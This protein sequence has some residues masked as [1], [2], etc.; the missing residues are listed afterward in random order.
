MK[1][2]LWWQ[3]R[4]QQFC[5]ASWFSGNLV[6]RRCNTTFPHFRVAFTKLSKEALEGLPH[7]PYKKSAYFRSWPAGWF[8]NTRKTS[9]TCSKTFSK[10]L[11][12]EA[13]PIPL[14]GSSK[15]S[16]KKS[17]YRVLWASWI[18]T[19]FSTHL[20]HLPTPLIRNCS[21]P[22]I[23]HLLIFEGAN[24]RH[25]LC[26]LWTHWLLEIKSLPS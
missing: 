2:P 25:T 3:G 13:L 9:L 11:L 5:F 6:E 24:S 14:P 4:A 18:S 8:S 21:Q 20:H 19:S 1:E 16:I 23:L 7:S 10:F 26:F 17:Y 12:R 22:C 15:P